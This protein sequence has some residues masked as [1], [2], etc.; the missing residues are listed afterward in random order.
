MIPFSAIMFDAS[1]P[2]YCVSRLELITKGI[3]LKVCVP[4]LVIQR[5]VKLYILFRTLRPTNH[6]LSSST[7]PY[8][9]NK[10][11]IY[12]RLSDQLTISFSVKSWLTVTSI[13]AVACST[14]STAAVNETFT[15]AQ[16]MG[17]RGEHGTEGVAKTKIKPKTNPS[18]LSRAQG[19]R[20]R[21]SRFTFCLA[22]PPVLCGHVTT[23]LRSL[24]SSHG[25]R[26]ARVFRKCHELFE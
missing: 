18:L 11:V 25:C 3:K 13:S 22:K 5:R 26:I 17:R 2:R 4:R 10:E 1:K 24:N 12:P 16:S 6:T 19:S 21:T 9:P 20:T 15:R 14:V 7:S 23:L 8:G